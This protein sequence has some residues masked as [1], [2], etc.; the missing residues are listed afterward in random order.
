MRISDW[1]ADVCSSDLGVARVR[2]QPLDMQAKLAADD[3][4]QDGDQD[5]NSENG[6][7]AA[8]NKIETIEKA[9][10]EGLFFRSI[11]V[12]DFFAGGAGFFEP[13]RSAERSVGK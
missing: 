7:Q 10:H 8:R 11:A 1:S 6:G 4:Q 2:I 3:G 13:F 12:D 9:T 5:T